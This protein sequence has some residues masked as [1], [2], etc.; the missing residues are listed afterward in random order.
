MFGRQFPEPHLHPY[1]RQLCLNMPNDKVGKKCITNRGKGKSYVLPSER[2]GEASAET[3]ASSADAM[4]RVRLEGAG[5]FWI[6]FL[7]LV[8][9]TRVHGTVHTT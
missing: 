2:R 1:L 3:S 9:Q 4:V 5:V 7:V 6:V 8:C